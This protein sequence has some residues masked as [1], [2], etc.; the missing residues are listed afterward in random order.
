[1]KTIIDGIITM[2]IIPLGV[3]A[4]AMGIVASLA[5]LILCSP[6]LPI[7]YIGQVIAEKLSNEQT[8]SE[9]L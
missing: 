8:K 9:E 7:A 3:L 6:F 5:L 4:L 2:L 1:M